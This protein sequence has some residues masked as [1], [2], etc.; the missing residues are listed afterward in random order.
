MGFEKKIFRQKNQDRVLPVGRCC[1]D[2][3]GIS[4]S[5][6]HCDFETWGM[7]EPSFVSL[8]MP[9]TSTTNISP[10]WSKNNHRTGIT[11]LCAPA[12]RRNLIN[13]LIKSWPDKINEL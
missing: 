4:R 11:T 13:D 2:L 8:A 12:Q 5:A 6:R 7:S 10:T 3:C 9:G 1:N